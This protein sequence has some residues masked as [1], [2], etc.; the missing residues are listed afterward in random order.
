M[1]RICPLLL[2]GDSGVM[3]METTALTGLGGVTWRG[4]AGRLEFVWQHGKVAIGGT[5]LELEEEACAPETN[6]EEVFR[7]SILVNSP[8]S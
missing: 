6:V 8:S 1:V 4:C 3:G 2:G 5:R 7:G